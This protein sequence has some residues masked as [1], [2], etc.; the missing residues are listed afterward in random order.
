MALAEAAVVVLQPK[1]DKLTACSLQ[2]QKSDGASLLA[3]FVVAKQVCKNGQIMA[4]CSVAADLSGLNS[5]VVRRKYKE[6]VSGDSKYLFS[7]S[8][9]GKHPKC[10]WVLD[11]P[12]AKQEAKTYIRSL[13]PNRSA[14]FSFSPL[15]FQKEMNNKLIPKYM[16]IAADEEEKALE[17]DPPTTEA[18]KKKT[19]TPTFKR[20]SEQTARRWIKNLG[21][22]VAGKGSS[23][24]FD[25]YN[26]PAVQ[27]DRARYL[28]EKT[29]SDK[30]TLRFEP[31][32]EKK[33]EYMKMD[34]KDRPNI[35][36]VMDESI[37]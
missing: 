34:E 36:L 3:L 20:I 32:E 10:A 9:R 16:A 21:F 13:L 22:K 7:F 19:I 1:I 4:A 17:G 14:E 37:Y 12:D 35:E 31:T 6:F 18:T 28:F 30:E 33:A 24:Y 8:N 27:E 29:E 11:H 23:N 26:K 25:G 15:K 5:E 2:M